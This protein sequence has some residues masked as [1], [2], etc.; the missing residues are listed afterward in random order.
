[1]KKRIGTLVLIFAMITGCLGG[2]LTAQ[3]SEEDLTKVTVILDYIPNTNHSGMY[4]ALDLGYYE[5]EGLDVE[6]IEPTEGAT[7]TLIANGVGTFGIAYQED[8]TLALASDD[9]LPIKAIATIIQHNTSGFVSLKS[10]NIKS[11]KS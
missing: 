6:I 9:P 4:A 5:E 2:V 10:S 8:V 1:M 3:A 7:N 11:K